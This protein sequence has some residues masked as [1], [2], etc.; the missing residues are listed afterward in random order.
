MV[1]LRVKGMSYSVKTKRDFAFLLR[2]ILALWNS[3]PSHKYQTCIRLAKTMKKK[4]CHISNI[5]QVLD[6][7]REQ[8][9]VEFY[10]GPL[11]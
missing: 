4:L 11:F 5:N 10:M 1:A 8:N 6:K 3:S 9:C 2:S 7:I